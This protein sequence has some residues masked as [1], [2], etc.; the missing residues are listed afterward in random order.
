MMVPVFKIFGNLQC[1]FFEVKS[2]SRGK[3]LMNKEFHHLY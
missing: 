3:M 2:G 1:I